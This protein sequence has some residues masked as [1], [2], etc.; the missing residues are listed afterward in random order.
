MRRAGLPWPGVLLGALFAAFLLLP[1]LVLLSR[2]LGADFWVTL[3]SPAVLDALRV[4]LWTTGVTLLVTVVTGTPLAFLLARREFPG[5]AL[6]DALLDLPVVLPPVVAGLGLLLTFGRGGLLG[7][8]LELAGVSLAFS[9]AAVVLAQLFTAAPFYLRAAKAGFAA[10]DR[11]AEAAALTD[12]A[13]RW[14]AFRFI[15]WPLAFPFL[16]EGLVLTWARALG[17]FGATILFAGSLQG[18]TRTVT[19]AIYGALDSDLGPALVLS[20]V[21]VVVAF[22]VLLAVRVLAARRD[23]LDTSSPG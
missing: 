20:A 21:M 23:R 8:G 19:L 3:R 22:S 18:R 16:L 1:T 9:P 11:D 6:L 10:V 14:A 4:S 7:P 17:E 12:G 13:G 5:R 2:G 15:T